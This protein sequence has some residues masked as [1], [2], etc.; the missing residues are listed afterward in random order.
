MQQQSWD[1]NLAP[2]THTCPP[3]GFDLAVMSADSFVLTKRSFSKSCRELK[4]LC[5]S[6]H[7]CK[8]NVGRAYQL[9]I[10]SLIR[11]QAPRSSSCGC[12][13]F[14]NR[15]RTTQSGPIAALEDGSLLPLAYAVPHACCRSSCMSFWPPN[16][17]QACVVG[18]TS[19]RWFHAIW[20]EVLMGCLHHRPV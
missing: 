11:V 18:C 15:S 20:P 4:K 9:V 6:Q 1:M 7:G 10:I 12:G 17:P 8:W 5:Q 13:C 3:C 19:S 14:S 2:G 16:E